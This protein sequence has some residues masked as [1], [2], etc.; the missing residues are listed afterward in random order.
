MNPDGGTHLSGRAVQHSP[1]ILIICNIVREPETCLSGA[2]AHKELHVAG[3]HQSS[4][5]TQDLCFKVNILGKELA[6]KAIPLSGVESEGPRGEE[7][8]FSAYWGLTISLS[9]RVGS[10]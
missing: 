1:D 5:C 10:K 7:F 8:S 2:L 6:E 3:I 4:E 9:L